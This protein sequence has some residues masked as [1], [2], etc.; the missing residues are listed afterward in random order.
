M[1]QLY[2]ARLS[3]SLSI[4]NRDVKLRRLE[5][6]RRSKPHCSASALS[7]IL[8]DIKQHGLPEL[9]NRDSMRE[10]RDRLATLMT[11]YG[12]MLPWHHGTYHTTTWNLYSVCIRLTHRRTA[13]ASLEQ[14]PHD[15]GA[16]YWIW[17]HPTCRWSDAFYQIPGLRIAVMIRKENQ[18]AI[19]W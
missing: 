18:T 4:M 15:A 12:T 8:A 1:L 5:A 11:P 17:I 9:T 10:G 14:R 13:H 19:R 16:V 6:F 3:F 2:F 7:Q